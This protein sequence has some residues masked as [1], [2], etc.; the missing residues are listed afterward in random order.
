[1]LNITQLARAVAIAAHCGIGQ[2]RKYTGEDYIVHPTEVVSILESYTTDEEAIAAAW[3]HDVV[4]DTHI[5]IE[6][7]YKIFQG[8]NV[9]E[10]VDWLT[11]YSTPK[12]GNRAVR[13]RKYAEQISRA[14]SI[15][16]T[17]KCCD[18][19][20]NSRT[21]FQY[22]PGFSKIY[23]QEKKEMLEMMTKA[24]PRA[25]AKCSEIIYNYESK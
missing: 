11:D 9:A 14:P 1:M 23:L 25:I 12:D 2:K 16:Q 13:K 15:V 17:I 10:Y 20:S 18:M 24:D 21:I 8:T 5:G 4:E 19:I 6:N 7:I 22:D 3:L